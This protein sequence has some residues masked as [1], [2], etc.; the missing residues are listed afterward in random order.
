MDPWTGAQCAF[1]EK[2]FYKNSDSLGSLS[3]NFKESLGFIVIVLF[4][5]LM[6][7][8][9]GFKTLMLLVLH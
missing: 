3:V 4:H 1:A 5:Q 2:V 7:L 6:P 8:R 9:P